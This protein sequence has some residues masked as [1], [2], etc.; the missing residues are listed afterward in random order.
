MGSF[1]IQISTKLKL[2][3]VEVVGLCRQMGIFE[4]GFTDKGGSLQESFK[5]DVWLA[6]IEWPTLIVSAWF[7]PSL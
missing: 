2:T 1:K 7:R 5:Y 6:A 3:V 4:A